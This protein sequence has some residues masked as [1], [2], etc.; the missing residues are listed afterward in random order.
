MAWCTR[1]DSQCQGT[2]TAYLNK[3][4]LVGFIEDSRKSTVFPSPWALLCLAH[5][6][7]KTLASRS[8]VTNRKLIESWPPFFLFF[9]I[10]ISFLS[11][12][13][14]SQLV[15]MYQTRAHVC[16]T[17]TTGSRRFLLS[18]NISLPCIYIP[19]TVFFRSRRSNEQLKFDWSWRFIV[20]LD[21]IWITMKYNTSLIKYDIIELLWGGGGRF[22]MLENDIFFQKCLRKCRRLIRLK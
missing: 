12:E 16:I 15:V 14:K 5:D 2:A 1:V 6:L 13:V 11:R 10:Y 22:K 19:C 17:A 9:T 18:S 3:S 4:R 7:P 20:Y 8:T 21:E